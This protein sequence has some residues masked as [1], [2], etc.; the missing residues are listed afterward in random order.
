M[1]RSTSTPSN[2]PHILGES[3]LDQMLAGHQDHTLPQLQKLWSYYRNPSEHQRGGSAAK[4]TAQAQGLPRRFTQASPDR[5]W[6][7]VIENDIAWRVHALV[8]FMVGK[9]IVIRSL[10]TDPERATAITELLQRT[11]EA[12]GGQTFF[13][14][15][16][17]LGSVYGHVDVLLR[18]NAIHP[19]DRLDIIS[20]TRAIPL[21]D[22]ADYRQ[23]QA[24]AIHAIRPGPPSSEVGPQQHSNPPSRL[25]RWFRGLTATDSGQ[26][27]TTELFSASHYERYESSAGPMSPRRRRVAAEPNPLGR[28]PV[29]HIQNLPQPFNFAGLSDVEPLIPLQDE[30]N[31]RLSDRANRVTFQSFKMYLGKGIEGFDEQPVGPGQMW[32]TDNPDAQIHEFGGDTHTPSEDSHI[33][34]IREALDKASGVSPIAAGVVGGKVGNLSSENAIRI[35]LLGLVARIQKKRSVYGAGIAR[36]CD[37]ILHSAHV[38][39][40]LRTDPAERRVRLDWPEPFP[41]THSQQIRNALDKKALGVPVEQLLAELGYDPTQTPCV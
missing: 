36:L 23:L 25:G 6:E 20:A 13:Q 14:D 28:L 35:V 10:A 29:I 33:R 32:S 30:L 7:I 8:D 2:T 21:L 12:N 26:H 19:H 11:F 17:L 41:D 22:P 39:G 24:Y 40:R 38:T 27:A 4:R 15:M 31:T 1:A 18:P 16:V 9:P 5:T 34:E 3:Q 37:L